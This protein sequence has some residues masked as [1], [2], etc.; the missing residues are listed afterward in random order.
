MHTMNPTNGRIG[1]GFYA[2][3][4]ALAFGVVSC[5]NHSSGEHI[6]PVDDPKHPTPDEPLANLQKCMPPDAAGDGFSVIVE[7]TG[8]VFGMES[9]VNG[10]FRMSFP[11]SLVIPEG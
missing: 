8:A 3:V 10:L 4:M 5:A 2:G 1:S 6:P 9:P 11:S 7:S